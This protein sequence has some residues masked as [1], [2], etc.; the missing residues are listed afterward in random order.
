MNEAFFKTLFLT[1]MV[2][3]F[4]SGCQIPLVKPSLSTAVPST[5]EERSLEAVR[6]PFASGIE[7]VRANVSTSTRGQLVLFGFDQ[8]VYRFSL[9]STGTRLRMDE[10]REAYPEMV[11]AINGV[12]FMEDLTPSG[13]FVGEGGGQTKRLF[14]ADKSA[15]ILMNNKLEILDTTT[16]S[17]RFD[18]IKEGAQTYPI[19]MKD[20]KE[21][22]TRDTRKEAR[23][24]WVGT[25]RA[26]KVWLGVLSDGE[27]SLYE[28]MKRLM[29]LGI[30]WDIVVNLDGGPSTGMFVKGGDGTIMKENLGGVPNVIFVERR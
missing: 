11:A 5:V 25:D 10:W 14:D 21:V 26:G 24:S 17:V 6:T 19:L 23:R 18:Y 28:L 12:Y 27:V 4:G 16:S 9:V 3:L 8:S 13:F 2:C 1:G 7:V 20:G 15:L 29:G 30:E 22:L